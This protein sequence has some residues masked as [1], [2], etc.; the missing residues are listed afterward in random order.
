MTTTQ[1]RNVNGVPVDQ[2]VETMQAVRKQPAIAKFVFRARNQWQDGGHCRATVDDYRGACDDHRRTEPYVFDL[3]EPPVLLGQDRGANPV[4]FLL[5]ALS[6][7]LTTSLVYHAAARGVEV[8]EV[9]SAYEGD[10]DLHGFLGMDENVR[11]GYEDIRVTF[12]VK[13][14]GDVS[15][16]VLDELVQTAR[17]RSPVF[18]V[19]SNGTRVSVTRAK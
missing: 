19:V 2:L 3:D 18:D 10:L 4:E 13:A 15:D 5:A 14:K 8:T 9:E 16:E 7:C 12:K 17:E 6:G 1:Q 11:N